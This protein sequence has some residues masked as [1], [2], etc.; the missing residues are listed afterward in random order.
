M[1]PSILVLAIL[2]SLGCQA[3]GTE[4]HHALLPQ[5]ST[6][7]VQE[8]QKVISTAT[9]STTPRISRTAFAD[10]HVL[11]LEH[12]VANTPKGR[13]ATGRTMTMPETFH[14]LSNGKQCVLL[15]VSTEQRYPLTFSCDAQS[16]KT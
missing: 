15:R 5:L 8:L 9:G 10:R 12:V 16:P 7:Q 14:L 13:L 11:V 6:D 3:N 4:F 1:K 2:L